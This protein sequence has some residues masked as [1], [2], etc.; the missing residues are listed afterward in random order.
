MQDWILPPPG[1]V[2]LPNKPM[3]RSFGVRYALLHGAAVLWGWVFGCY[4]VLKPVQAQ[5]ACAMPASGPPHPNLM[6]DSLKRFG[7][8]SDGRSTRHRHRAGRREV[9]DSWG[10]AKHWILVDDALEVDQWRPAGDRKEWAG[11]G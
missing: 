5:W 1:I 2:V 8:A 3:I 7:Y 11:A 6:R 4:V 10:E 9:S